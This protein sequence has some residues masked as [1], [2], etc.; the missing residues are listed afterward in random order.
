[1]RCIAHTHPPQC[2]DYGFDR[3]RLA[4]RQRVPGEPFCFG[5]IGRHVAAK[6]IDQLVQAFRGVKGNAQLRIWGRP[7][8]QL[9]AALHALADGDERIQ[10]RPEYRNESIAAEVLSQCDAVVVPSIWCVTP[11]T[12]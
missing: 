1:L 6:G 7:E 5:F 2:A 9:T 10:W 12:Q 11:A 4:G 8:G 3:A